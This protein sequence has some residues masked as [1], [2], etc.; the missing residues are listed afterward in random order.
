MIAYWIVAGFFT[1]I[2]W[3]YG[4]N[5]VSTYLDK[6]DTTI[7]QKADTKQSSTKGEKHDTTI[8]K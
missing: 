5:F 6:P 4:D 1:A 7:E 3:H 8:D 2:G